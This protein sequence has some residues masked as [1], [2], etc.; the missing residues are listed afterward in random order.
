MQLTD[1]WDPDTYERF[2]PERDRPVHDLLALLSPTDRGRAA[3]LGCGT[4]RH[5]P[6]LHERVGAATTVG[7][8]ASERMLERRRG[9]AHPA[10]SFRHGDLADLDGEWDVLFANASLHWLPDH[11]TLLPHLVG[12]LRR[13]GQLAFQVPA[14]FDHPSHTVADRVG[15]DF[16]LAPL[17]RAAGSASP[18]GYAEILW[19]AGLR[20][21]DVTQRVYGVEMPRTD[22]VIAWVSGSLLTRF[23]AELPPDRFAEFRTAYRQQFLDELGDRDGDQS[24]FYAFPRT[25]CWGRRPD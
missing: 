11:E 21:L 5:S 9:D 22:D 14:N 20:D 4:G 19:S 6:L 1:T 23:E 17:H 8:D 16:G 12:R 2:R 18:A 10:V 25:L 15:R 3:D 13:G 24:Y 7:I